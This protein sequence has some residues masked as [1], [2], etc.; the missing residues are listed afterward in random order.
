VPQVTDVGVR[1]TP[2]GSGS[3]PWVLRLKDIVCMAAA[4]GIGCASRP[5]MDPGTCSIMLG[6]SR[7][8]R[9][10]AVSQSASASIFRLLPSRP[11][12][13]CPATDNTAYA[14]GGVFKPVANGC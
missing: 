12:A 7:Y 3:Q 5:P 10:G 14:Y 11:L 6:S 8:D 9:G 4:D 2:V 1:L 13:L